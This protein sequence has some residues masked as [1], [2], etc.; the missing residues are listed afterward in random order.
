M[1]CGS[2]EITVYWFFGEDFIV[3]CGKGISP[4]PAY[5]MENAFDRS[6]RY[7]QKSHLSKHRFGT[8]WEVL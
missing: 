5:R 8:R 6:I 1:Q 7:M 4:L 2:I 3:L